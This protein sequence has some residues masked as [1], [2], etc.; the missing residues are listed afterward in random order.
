GDRPTTV[1]RWPRRASSRAA[2]A[3]MPS[4][5]PVMTMIF[6]SPTRRTVSRTPG[7][8]R[9]GAGAHRPQRADGRW[10]G[11]QGRMPV[12]SGEAGWPRSGS[13]EPSVDEVD[14]AGDLPVRVAGA[15]GPLGGD[16]LIEVVTGWLVAQVIG[17]GAD[18]VPGDRLGALGPQ[19]GAQVGRVVGAAARGRPEDDGLAGHGPA[20]AHHV[21]TG[22]VR[23]G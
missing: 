21:P 12:A 14:K 18:A 11:E 1:S 13:G 10:A 17:E 23:A 16:H 15:G 4:L 19:H 9:P 20:V 8:G 22:A 5:A 2:A 6:E 7:W 3:P